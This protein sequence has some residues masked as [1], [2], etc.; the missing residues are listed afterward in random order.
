ML[1]ITA[2]LPRPIFRAWRRRWTAPSAPG[3]QGGGRA[4]EEG[5]AVTLDG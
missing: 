1:L 4:V 5:F 3:A 2:G